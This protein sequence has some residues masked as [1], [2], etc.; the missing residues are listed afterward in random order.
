M[1]SPDYDSWKLKSPE[2]LERTPNVS[3]EMCPDCLTIGQWRYKENEWFDDKECSNFE[4]Q[5]VWLDGF[6]CEHIL[7]VANKS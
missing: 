5:G 4:C 6:K 2:Y 7:R 1:S 3:K